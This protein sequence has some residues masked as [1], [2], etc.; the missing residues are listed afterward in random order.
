M[1]KWMIDRFLPMWA[2]ETVLKENRQ[3]RRQIAQLNRKLQEANAYIQGIHVG[4]RGSKRI[5][6][7]ERGGQE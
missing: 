7:Y 2:K 1:K 6:V 4:L 5:R 3:L